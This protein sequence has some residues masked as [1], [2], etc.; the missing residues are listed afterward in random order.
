MSDC[1]DSGEVYRRRTETHTKTPHNFVMTSDEELQK[2]KEHTSER[3]LITDSKWADNNVVTNYSVIRSL[4]KTKSRDEHCAGKQ[5]QW[6]AYC[7]KCA[8]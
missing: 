1:G 4:S 5:N 3:R 7:L 8:L 2:M 6:L